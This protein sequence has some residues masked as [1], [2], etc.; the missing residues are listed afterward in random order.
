MPD[1]KGKIYI[2]RLTGEQFKGGVQDCPDCHQ[3]KGTP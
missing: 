2:V 1:I 3:K